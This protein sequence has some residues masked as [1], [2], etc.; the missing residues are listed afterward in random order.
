M[1]NRLSGAMNEPKHRKLNGTISC[2]LLLCHTACVSHT[3]EHFCVLLFALR[4]WV[5]HSHFTH[6]LFISQP[7]TY[8]TVSWWVFKRRN[9]HLQCVSKESLVKRGKLY[10]NEVTNNLTPKTEGELHTVADACMLF[11]YEFC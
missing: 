1:L 8:S 3:V 5:I 6:I 4:F 9:A 10:G 11:Y 7:S 2:V